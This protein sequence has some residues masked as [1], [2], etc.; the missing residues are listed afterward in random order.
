VP[1]HRNTQGPGENLLQFCAA[2]LLAT[3]VL[4]DDAMEVIKERGEAPTMFE[5]CIVLLQSTLHKL[6]REVARFHGTLAP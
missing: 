4:D 5:A 2:S 6:K 1:T 3:L